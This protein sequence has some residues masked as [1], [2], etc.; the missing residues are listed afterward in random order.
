MADIWQPTMHRIAFHDDVMK[1][2]HF[3]D[4]SPFV[5]GIRRSPLVSPHKDQWRGGL[6]FS[7]FCART[8]GW[9]NN[10]DAGDLTRH[11]AHYE[12][13]VMS[14]TENLPRPYLYNGIPYAKKDGK[15]IETEAC[16]LPSARNDSI[17]VSM[18]RKSISCWR[19][20]QITFY[21]IETIVLLADISLNFVSKGPI[22]SS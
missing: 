19:N 1:W 20:L 15:C 2:K 13:I 12:V 4:Y 7:L 10:R 16:Q 21:W 22:G 8:N 17:L 11:G 9:A 5:R 3:P 6:M 18:I 14:L